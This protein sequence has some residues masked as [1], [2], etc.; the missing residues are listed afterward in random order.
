MADWSTLPQD[1]LNSIA[2]RL[3]SVVELKRFRSICS[4]WRSSVYKP[5]PRRPIIHFKPSRKKNLHHNMEFLSRSV[6]YRVTLSSSS[7]Q[8]WLIKTEVDVD[9]GKLRLLD[10]LSG[11]AMRP[12]CDSLD[13]LEF[14]IS[15]IREA[16]QV[17][18]WGTRRET[19]DRFKRVILVKDKRGNQ[20]VLGIPWD[21]KIKYWK[22]RRRYWKVKKL[23]YRFSDVIVHKGLTYALDSTGIVLWISS[24]L[25]FYRYG[26]PLGDNITNGCSGERR[27]VECCGEL[28]I[29]DRLFGEISRKRKANANFVSVET[30]GFKVY[31]FEEDLGKMV[32]V[33]SLGDNAFVMA[34]DTCFSVLACEYYGCLQDS[35]YFTEQRQI[36][37]FKLDNGN[38][39]SIETMSE[40]SQSCFQMFVPT[41]L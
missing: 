33:E 8:G 15:E 29:V 16:Y 4:S 12:L 20:R 24:K 14:T 30:V 23:A 5:F 2:V 36:K 34:S 10:P 40:Y 32:E 19:R 31:K 38:G 39:S 17:L 27:F 37:V 1:L 41:F 28:Y 22:R 21:G 7:R 13:L 9:S 26:P 35:I 6:F 18:Y 11:L 3:F 25:K